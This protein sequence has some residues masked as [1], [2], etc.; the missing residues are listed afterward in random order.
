MVDLL[1]PRLLSS[2]PASYLRPWW[3]SG[4]QW[5]GSL[6][7]TESWRHHIVGSPRGHFPGHSWSLCYEEQ[8]YAVMGLLLLTASRRLF[9]ASAIVTGLTVLAGLSCA[10][11]NVPVGGF[12]FDGNWLLFAAGILVY[13]RINYTEGY[14][15]TMLDAILA[16]GI[17]YAALCPIPVVVTD[18]PARLATLVAFSFALAISV[19]HRWDACLASATILRPLMWCGTMCYSMYLVHPPIARATS[20]ALYRLGIRG[21]LETLLVTTPLCVALSIAAGW[22]FHRVVEKRFLNRPVESA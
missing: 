17:I 8:F 7:L 3:Y 14:R 11:L 5:L 6:T 22:L 19:A 16:L 1:V 10:R 18:T 9:A 15:S 20:K 21:D 12:F 4:W 2:E 13:Y